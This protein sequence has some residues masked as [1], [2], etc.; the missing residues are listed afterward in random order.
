MKHDYFNKRTAP[1]T[2][3]RFQEV[4]DNAF[5]KVCEKY[6]VNPEEWTKTLVDLYK[7]L[8]TSWDYSN[9]YFKRYWMDRVVEIYGLMLHNEVMN[10][11]LDLVPK[12]RERLADS[13]ETEFCKVFK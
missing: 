8:K 3:F 9:P 11:K 12:K 13:V 7:R 5:D 4:V 1:G 6:K 10:T 2:F